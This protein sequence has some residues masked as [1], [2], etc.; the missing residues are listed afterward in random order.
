MRLPRIKTPDR[1]TTYHIRA[2]ISGPRRWYPLQKQVVRSFIIRCV[3]RFLKLYFCR[4]VDLD[5]MGTHIHLI[6]R[7][8]PYRKLSRRELH[9]RARAYY[10]RPVDRPQTQR[11]WIR[12]N[13]RLFDVSAF[14]KNVEGAIVRWF[15]RKYDRRGSLFGE[16][17]ASTILETDSDVLNCMFYVDLNPVRAGLVDRPEDWK[18]GTTWRRIEGKDEGMVPLTELMPGKTIEECRKEYKLKLYWRGAIGGEEGKRQIPDEVIEEELERG[19]EFGWGLDRHR[20]VSKGVVAGSYDT[21][22]EWLTKLRKRV[23]YRK[24][25]DPIEQLG[26]RCYTL[27]PQRKRRWDLAEAAVVPG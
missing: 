13:Y 24:R 5:I 8:E 14:M 3:N 25:V 10:S 2:R 22:S 16:R 7:F 1:V 4:L 18:G 12:F 21:V 20:W 15:N 6:V 26:G 17:F 27:R 11:E 23:I 9:R 19:F